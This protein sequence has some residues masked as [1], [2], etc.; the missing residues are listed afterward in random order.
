MRA[1]LPSL[2]LKLALQRQ[3]PRSPS[4]QGSSP[5]P[6]TW[7]PPSW[8]L[9]VLFLRR[10][11]TES[12]RRVY[13]H[14]APRGLTLALK[15]TKRLTPVQRVQRDRTETRV[16]PSPV[17]P[18]SLS[19]SLCLLV[20]SCHSDNSEKKKQKRKKL[21]RRVRQLE[22]TVEG[23]SHGLIL[24]L[25]ELQDRKTTADGRKSVNVDALSTALSDLSTVEDHPDSAPGTSAPGATL[26]QP[27]SE[28]PARQR[29]SAS[30]DTS[31]V[32]AEHVATENDSSMLIS[33][34]RTPISGLLKPILDFMAC[35]EVH[36]LLKQAE[37]HPGLRN[38]QLFDLLWVANNFFNVHGG[39]RY[40]SSRRRG[41]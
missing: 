3:H 24:A 1:P 18:S 23:L 11:L 36:Q 9:A 34:G 6:Q 15:V 19:Y 5:S 32:G 22:K 20:A 2:S 17:C 41:H 8:S 37:C 21:S 38:T 4:L 16:I 30:Q 28:P 27:P 29:E 12:Q 13:V 33:E 31:A 14:R 25:T 40:H 35:R 39:V 26:P 10:R 7:D